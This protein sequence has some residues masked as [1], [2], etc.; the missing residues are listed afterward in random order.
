M[1]APELPVLYVLY[2]GISTVEGS[3]RPA[4]VCSSWARYRSISGHAV[5]DPYQNIVHGLFG[6]TLLAIKM[7]IT[8]VSTTSSLDRH[9]KK[10]EVYLMTISLLCGLMRKVRKGDVY[11]DDKQ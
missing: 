9:G 4:E 1:L 3:G 7:V 8:W 2:R 6:V 11:H 5:R 10:E